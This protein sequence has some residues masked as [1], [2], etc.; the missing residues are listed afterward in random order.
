METK[1]GN[2]LTIKPGDWN[3]TILMLLLAIVKRFLALI[4][5]TISFK[6]GGLALSTWLLIAGHI[7]SWHWFLIFI[8]I[9]G[10]REMFKVMVAK[11]GPKV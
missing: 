5:K 6:A 4:G 2:G 9:I 8:L 11:M 1:N 3:Q 7:Q 10:G